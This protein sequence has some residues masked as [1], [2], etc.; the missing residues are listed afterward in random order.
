MLAAR[1]AGLLSLL[2]P[3]EALEVMMLHSVA[4]NLTKGG[5]IQNWP[6]CEPHHSA[7]MAALVGGGLRAKTGEISLENHGVLFI[8]ELAE[9]S[10]IVLDLLRQSLEPGSVVVAC[11]NH[12]V[13]CLARF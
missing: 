4:S 13:T 2:D 5:L 7:S 9:F 12:H 8:D 11:A 6:F 3:A 10:R 1:L